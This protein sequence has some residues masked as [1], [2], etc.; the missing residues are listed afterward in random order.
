MFIQHQNS[1]IGRKQYES[2]T[3]KTIAEVDRNETRGVTKIRKRRY[4]LR[5]WF[6]TKESTKN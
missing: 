5:P 1:H 2:T 6:L 3:W 4:M